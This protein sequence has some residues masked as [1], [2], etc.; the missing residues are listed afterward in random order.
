MATLAQAASG[1]IGAWVRSP[2]RSRSLNATSS[3]RTVT[4]KSIM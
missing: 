4:A 3:D 1:V 2:L